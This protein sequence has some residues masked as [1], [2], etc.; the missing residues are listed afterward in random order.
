MI[1]STR[2]RYAL[3]VMI[4]M[5]EQGGDAYIP[6][7]D[8]AAR[9]GVSPKY[10][11]QI[12]PALVKEHLVTGIHGKGGGYRLAVDP[13]ECSVLSILQAT[14]GSLSSVTCLESGANPC[15]RAKTCQTLPVWKK[16]NSLIEDY[17]GGVFLTDLCRKPS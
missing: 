11:E 17:L 2:G 9:Q 8:I 13:A 6:M 7:K 15:E 1:V 3:R 12:M 5:A 16:L 10:M 14:E 4:D